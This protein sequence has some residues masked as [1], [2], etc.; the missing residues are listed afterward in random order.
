MVEALGVVVVF[1][2]LGAIVVV[3]ALEVVVRAL[4]DKVEIEVLSKV[5]ATL[6]TF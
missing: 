5:S 2:T 6:K 3:E 1:E 4:E